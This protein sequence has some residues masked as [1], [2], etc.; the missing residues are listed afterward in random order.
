MVFKIIQLIVDTIAIILGGVLLLRFWMQA[1]RVRPTPQLGQAV[2]TLTDWLVRPL[3]RV[4]PGVGG[5]DWAS[6]FGALLVIFLATCV[7]FLAGAT[8]GG[9]AIMTVF[10]F[11]NWILW[12]L[13]ILLIAEA[14]MSW[15]NPHAP[16]APFLHE[17]NAPLLRPLRKV[18][19]P[20]G[21]LDWSMLAALLIIQ[22]ARMVLAEAFT[23]IMRP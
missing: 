8:I 18:I 13:T 6:L 22:I 23:G 14:I 4:L 9:V 16:A 15:V 2:F 12:G 19:P 21:G 5:Y 11:L 17:M 20:M 3:R 10:T 7:Y 1:M